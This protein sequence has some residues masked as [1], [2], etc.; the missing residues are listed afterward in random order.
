[1]GSVLSIAMSIRASSEHKRRMERNGRVWYRVME[2]YPRS[3]QA[4]ELGEHG[5]GGDA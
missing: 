2:R 5:D 1:M 4:I 3:D